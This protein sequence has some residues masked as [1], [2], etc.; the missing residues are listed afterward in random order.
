[1]SRQLI[2]RNADLKR[3]QDEG[4]DIEIRGSYLVLRQVPYVNSRR[5]V[6]FGTLVS[7]LVVAGDQTVTPSSH[8]VYFIGDRPCTKD[9]AEIIQIINES[10]TRELDKDLAIHHTFSSKPA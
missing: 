10:A 5:K 1:M 7:E 6:A 4:Y 9:G 8:V 3:L 2:S